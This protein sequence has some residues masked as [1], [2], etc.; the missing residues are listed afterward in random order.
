MLFADRS[1]LRLSR[2]TVRVTSTNAAA[3]IR[4]GVTKLPLR[5][6]SVV[7]VPAQEVELGRKDVI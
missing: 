1:L 7:G 6:G 3:T 4:L 2:N 5:R